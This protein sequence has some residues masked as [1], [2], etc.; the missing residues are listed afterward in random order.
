MGPWALG[1]RA[2]STSQHG[3][4]HPTVYIVEAF[5]WILTDFGYQKSPQ[6]SLSL[7]PLCHCIFIH[8]NQSSAYLFVG[9]GPIGVDILSN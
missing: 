2:S 8:F 4:R 6:T 9:Q 7:A 1:L 3:P 5:E